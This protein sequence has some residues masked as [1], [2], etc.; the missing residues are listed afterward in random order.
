MLAQFD[1]ANSPPRRREVKLE[2][3]KVDDFHTD[4]WQDGM[5]LRL[6]IEFQNCEYEIPFDEDKIIH[7]YVEKSGNRWNVGCKRKQS[8]KEP[9][10]SHKV[11]VWIY[12]LKFNGLIF[13]Q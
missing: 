7:F 2:V 3:Q 5:E 12:Y 6:T 4:I 13:Y 8:W 11:E 10:G 9:S 1:N